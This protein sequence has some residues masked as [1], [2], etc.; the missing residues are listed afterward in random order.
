MTL[1]P[2]RVHNGKHFD[3]AL[4]VGESGRYSEVI[5]NRAAKPLRVM[6]VLST[7]IDPA[8][9]VPTT[10]CLIGHLRRQGKK[11]G[12]TRRAA[13]FVGLALGRGD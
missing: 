11:N 9:H 7:L 6:K 1:T 8:M 5:V 12:A 13:E 4:M 3:F 2:V 10:E